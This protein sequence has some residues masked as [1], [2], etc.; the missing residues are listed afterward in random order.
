MLHILQKNIQDESFLR[1]DS[2]IKDYE[3]IVV[4]YTD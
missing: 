2:G 3:R 4:F 1:Y